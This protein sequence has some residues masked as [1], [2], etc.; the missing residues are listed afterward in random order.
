M[1]VSPAVCFPA[2]SKWSGRRQVVALKIKHGISAY[3]AAVI[4]HDHECQNNLF[5]SL[6]LIDLPFHSKH[7]P[8]E[9]PS[10]SAALKRFRIAIDTSCSHFR[11]RVE[12]FVQSSAHVFL[13]EL[14]SNTQT[15]TGTDTNIFR[16]RSA[17]YCMFRDV[18]PR[19]LVLI[20][21]RVCIASENNISLIWLLTLCIDHFNI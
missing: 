17:L 6:S 11:P 4:S 20:H 7:S 14:K 19:L 16:T 2:F 5:L 15:R 10:P 9:K 1:I 8:S 13:G 12:P 3:Q 18:D 21:L